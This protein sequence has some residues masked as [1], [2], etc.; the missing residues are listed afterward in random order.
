[1]SNA[2]CCDLCDGFYSL[3]TQTNFRLDM[4]GG[5]SIDIC[6]S[7]SEILGFEKDKSLKV[8]VLEILATIVRCRKQSK[9][10]YEQLKEN[11]EQ[12]LAEFNANVDDYSCTARP[13]E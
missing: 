4:T 3:E 6:P 8:P 12:F 2:K 5:E 7:C 9:E 1:M 10:E 11:D 13:G